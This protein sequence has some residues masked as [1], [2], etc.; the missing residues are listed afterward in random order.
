MVIV[1]KGYKNTIMERKQ[2]WNILFKIMRYSINGG[3]QP[4]IEV[5]PDWE[6]LYKLCKHHKIESM[7]D[8]GLSGLSEEQQ[9]PEEIK[10]KLQKATKTNIAREAVQFFSLEE[11]LDVF[12]EEGIDCM[13][14]KGALLKQFY[15]KP[16]LRVM[17]DLDILYRS[18]QKEQMHCIMN[19]LGYEESYQDVHEDGYIRKPYMN[20]EMHHSMIAKELP[21]GD[22]YENVWERLRLAEGKKH[23]Y[24]FSWEDYYI[25]MIVHLSKHFRYCGSGIRSIVDIWVFLNQMGES[26]DGAYL[27]REFDKLGLAAFEEHIRKLAAIWFDGAASNESYDALTCFVVE[28]GIFGVKKNKKKQQVIKTVEAGKS[29]A[30]CTNGIWWALAFPSYSAMK[31]NYL[32]LEG[33]PYLLVFAW[34]HRL[35]R[36]A[37]FR[38]KSAAKVIKNNIIAEDEVNEMIELFRFLDL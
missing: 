1:R 12:E 29:V 14:L 31:K 23:I 28:S 34:A 35:I 16:Y 7:V 21:R 25:Y 37:F 38:R 22:Y 6:Y 8:N 26:L 30:E 9:P 27:E 13:P 3:E 20:V 11:I 17:A 18:E 24:E 36:A 2:Q 33:R 32:Y 4:D 19:E 15:G 5:A 10:R